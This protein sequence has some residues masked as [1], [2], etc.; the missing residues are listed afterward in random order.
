MKNIRTLWK[1]IRTRWDAFWIGD[2]YDS[3]KKHLSQSDKRYLL[4]GNFIVGIVTVT[5]VLLI[6]GFNNLRLTR[7]NTA[8]LEFIMNMV[9]SYMGSATE[10]EYDR[11]VETIRKDLVF[12]DYSEGLQVY[13]KHIPNTSEKCSVCMGDNMTQTILVNL[14][15]GESYGLDLSEDG[16]VLKDGKG[17]VQVVFGYDEISQASIRIVKSPGRE[18]GF[19]EIERGNG[20]VSLHRMKSLF[21]DGC[22]DE[23]LK[24]VEGQEMEEFVV[25]DTR[26]NIFYP[27][28]HGNKTSI[29]DYELEI[30]YKHGDYEIK[31]EFADR[32]E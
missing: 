24:I 22:I 17:N 12:G 23:I 15:T 26:K 5:L 28:E 31:M 20:I 4:Y 16:E 18:K 1:G 29:G 2:E 21:C 6:N 10:N 8:D 30:E 19:V 14:N 7:Q 3:S 25:L 11:I 27:I 9:K 32:K 13:A